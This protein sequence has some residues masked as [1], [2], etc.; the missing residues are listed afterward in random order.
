MQTHCIY[1]NKERIYNSGYCVLL[2]I[3]N[4]KVQEI[5]MSDLLQVSNHVGVCQHDALGHASC[6]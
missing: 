2:T 4:V 6:A 5:R 1:Y 3:S